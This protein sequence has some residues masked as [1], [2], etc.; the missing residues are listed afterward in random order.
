[1]SPGGQLTTATARAFG[2]PLLIVRAG[3]TTPAD[4][5]CRLEAEG[6]RV[7]NVAGNRESIEPGIGERSAAFLTV[8]FG[9]LAM[10]EVGQSLDNS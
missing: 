8:V 4:V 10:T 1:M 6:V 5:R 9:A 2:K 3:E 7:L